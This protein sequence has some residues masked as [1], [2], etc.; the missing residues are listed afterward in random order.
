MGW[1]YKWN[2]IEKTIKVLYIFLEAI[3]LSISE[4]VLENKWC[5][6]NSYIR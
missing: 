2:E 4:V 1:E 3:S 5:S 6:I